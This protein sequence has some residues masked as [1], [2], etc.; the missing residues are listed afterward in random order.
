VECN[1]CLINELRFD[2][3]IDG[4]YNETVLADVIKYLGRSKTLVKVTGNLL[5]IRESGI[6]DFLDFCQDHMD[7]EEVT[8]RIYGREWRPLMEIVTILDMQWI[9]EI[10]IKESIQCYFQP[11]VNANNEIYAYE[12]LARFTR[13]DGSMIYPQEIFAAARLRGRLY[14]LDRLCRMTAVKYAAQ[15]TGKIFINF[16]PTSIYTP[17]FCLKSTVQLTDQLGVDPS[18]L[19]FEVVETEEVED[20]PHLKRILAYYKEQ[21]FSY[22]LDDVGGGYSTMEMLSELKPNY[23]KLD[24]KYVQGVSHDHAKQLIASAFLEK[25]IEIAS[26]PLAEGI[27]CREDYEWL[28]QRGYQLF[29]GYLF[30][31]PEPIR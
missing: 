3:R 18:R 30:G 12:S 24:M 31:K 29:Q 1:S 17:E 15:L 6:R 11:I 27:E 16:I 5:T 22:A 9:D 13:E 28:K 19:V 2:I 26:I 10:I 8:F 4:D 7:T 25:A 23:M 21:G 14:A 20:L